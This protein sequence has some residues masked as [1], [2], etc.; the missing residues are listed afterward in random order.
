MS[1][2]DLHERVLYPVV[3]VRATENGGG[4]GTIIYCK[5]DPKNLNDYITLVLTNHHVIE[6]AI[7]YKEDWDSILKKQMKKEFVAPVNVE[8]FDYENMSDVVSANNHRAVIVAYDKHHDLA[9]LRLE[10]S[11][12]V[13]YVAKLIGESDIKA[14]KLF[15]PTLLCG[16]SLLHDPFVTTGHITYLKELI[17]NKIYLMST[18]ASIFGNSGGALYLAETTEFI[19]VPSRIQTLQLGFGLDVVNFMGFSVHPQ[20][21]YEFFREQ[22]LHFVFDDKDD[23]YRSL[24]RRKAKQ[25]KAIMM[26]DPVNIATPLPDVNT[27]LY[28][29]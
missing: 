29:G 1:L 4:S 10:R 20:R 28:E 7:S 8:I 13:P 24:E 3:R 21:L 18:S 27:P 26:Q 5:Q 17:E 12:K 2:Q 23:F 14:I 16:A 6:K 11:S 22:E 9:L 19:G 25:R 15:M